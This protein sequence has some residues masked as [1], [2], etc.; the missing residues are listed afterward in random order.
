[1][2]INTDDV[3]VGIQR[4][5]AKQPILSYVYV[6]ASLDLAVDRQTSMSSV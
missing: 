6:D 2:Q 3:K 5:A 4:V 1:M